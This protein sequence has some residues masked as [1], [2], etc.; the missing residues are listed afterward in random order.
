[1]TKYSQE[2]F[3]P[4]NPQKLI[5]NAKPFYRSSWELAMMTFLDSHPSVIQWA[6]ESVKI[7]YVNPLT[8]RRSQYVPDFLVLYQDKSGKQQAELVEIKPKKEAMLENAK[9][10]RDKAFLI[11][12]Q[13][14]WQAALVWCKKNGV[15]FRLITEDQLWTKTGSQT[16]RRI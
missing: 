4:K 9:S 10:K 14:K 15:T 16:K 3:I 2:Y 5:G 7:P 1:M 11:V 8:G 12:N 13:A 6:S